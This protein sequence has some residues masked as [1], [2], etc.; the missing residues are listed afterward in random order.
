MNKNKNSE[1]EE[2]K[3]LLQN[4]HDR[5]GLNREI[6]EVKNIRANTN[7]ALATLDKLKSDL[8]RNLLYILVGAI[9]GYLPN[10]LSED[11]TTKELE[12]IRKSITS[13]NEFE[14]EN[15]AYLEQMRSEIK[16]LKSKIDSLKKE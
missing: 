1:R 9:I 8:W 4:L 13:K 11:K 6:L 3:E 15:Q 16:S 14:I 2:T 12:L 10:L 7:L 5:K